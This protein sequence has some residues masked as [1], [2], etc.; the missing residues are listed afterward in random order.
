[1]TKYARYE[2]K[3]SASWA[4]GTSGSPDA[5]TAFRVEDLSFNSENS[6][7]V[8]TNTYVGEYQGAPPRPSGRYGLIGF[9]AEITPTAGGAPPHIGAL[10]RASGLEEFDVNPV[11]PDTGICYAY[12]LGDLHL[13]AMSPAGIVD[14]VDISVNYDREQSALLGCV[15]NAQIRLE[16]NMLPK[17]AFNGRGLIDDSI[18]TAT[19]SGHEEVD[20]PQ[21]TN[22]LNP[23]PVQASDFFIRDHEYKTVSYTVNDFDSS[24]TSYVVVDGD[25]TLTLTPHSTFVVTGSSIA[26]TYTVVSST[27]DSIATETTVYIEED[28][29]AHQG[30]PISSPVSNGIRQVKTAYSDLIVLR[31]NIDLGNMID[32]RSDMNGSFGFSQPL[33]TKRNPTAD[34]QIECTALAEFNPYNIFIQNKSLDIV[35]HLNPGNGTNES[36]TIFQTVRVASYPSKT[37]VNNKFVYDISFMQDI[38]NG[39]FPLCLVWTDTNIP[40]QYS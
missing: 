7:T 11:S 15:L 37:V 3:S 1:M 24:P 4:A 13:Q 30:S 31:Y 9:T 5:E 16:A 20:V 21:I 22:T 14:P 36:I 2:S 25:K 32:E 35:C 19:T 33:I 17:I 40:K 38:G 34:C 26:G 10:L 12:Q 27:Y 8:A 23:V 29:S 39:T 18:A 28:L 6:D